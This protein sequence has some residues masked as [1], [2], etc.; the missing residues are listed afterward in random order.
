MRALSDDL[1][2][3]FQDNP[4]WWSRRVIT[5]HPLGGRADGTPRRRRRRATQDGEVFGFPG[6]HVLDG[7]LMPGP[8]GANPS[9]TIAA[10]ADRACD[11]ILGRAGPVRAPA[12][13]PGHH[14]ARAG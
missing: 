2:A 1:G 8:V 13:G 11:R 10:F 5:V 7:S 4:L 6:L 12:G 9:L 14:A 3:R